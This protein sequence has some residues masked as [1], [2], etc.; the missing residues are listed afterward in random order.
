[1]LAYTVHKAQ[2]PRRYVVKV[3]V[4][5]VKAFQKDS[6]QGRP[7][8]AVQDANQFQDEQLWG[9]SKELGISERSFVQHSDKADYKVRLFA[10]KQEVDFS[11]LATATTFHSLAEHGSI[12]VGDKGFTS[13]T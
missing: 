8:C 7:D 5:L 12:V 10:A 13:V 2:K 1:V 3:P 6:R 11:E 9:I 4:Q